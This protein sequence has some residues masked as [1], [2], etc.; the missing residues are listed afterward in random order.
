M[1]NLLKREP[2]QIR[3]WAFFFHTEHR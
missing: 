2:R 1:R 3:T